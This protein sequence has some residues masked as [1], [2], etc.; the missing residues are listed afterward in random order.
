MKKTASIIALTLMFLMAFAVVAMAAQNLD[1]SAVKGDLKSDYLAT[2]KTTSLAYPDGIYIA[3]DANGIAKPIHSGYQANTDACASCHATHTAVGASLLQWATVSDA[4]DACHDGTITD[5]YNVDGG[6]IGATGARTSGGLFG[7]STPI[8]TNSLSRHNVGVVNISAAPGGN[9]AGT[10]DVNGTWGVQFEC[11]SCHTPHGMGGNFRILNPDANGIAMAQKVTKELATTTDTLNF[12]ASK[13]NWI[14]GYPYSV[15]TGVYVGA[16]SVTATKVTTGFTTDYRNGIVTFTTAPA[17]NVYL[18]YV[19]GLRITGTVT[20]KLTATEDVQYTTGLNSFC[21]ACH[22]DYNTEKVT[23]SGSNLNGTYK[24]AYRHKV[25]M[26]WHGTVPG[27]KFGQNSEVECLTCHV[28]HGTDQQW[29]TDWA[30]KSGWAGTVT[31][32]DAGSSALKRLPNMSTCEAC[33]QKGAAA[34]Y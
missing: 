27:L 1:P 16:D 15:N 29:W 30:A 17:G 8:G 24:E 18:S 6:M 23:K 5:T 32:E 3:K 11:T 28:A 31:G 4:C 12:K 10:A 2:P 33:H 34:N 20:N 7:G 26:N 22:T 9:A 14:K 21:G 19:P 25:G 13:A